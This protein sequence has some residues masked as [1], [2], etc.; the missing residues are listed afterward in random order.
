MNIFACIR[1]RC[2]QRHQLKRYLQFTQTFAAVQKLERSHLLIWE[3]KH[4]RLF[5]S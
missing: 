5:I 3:Q 2:E 1:A 4:R